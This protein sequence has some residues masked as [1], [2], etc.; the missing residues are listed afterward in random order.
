MNI[1]YCLPN[2][3]INTLEQIVKN[4]G[5]PSTRQRAGLVLLASVVR[6]SSRPASQYSPVGLSV[7]LDRYRKFG[8]YCLLPAWEHLQM[9]FTP[10]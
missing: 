5:D 10:V 4:H 7:L 1:L 6:K 8:F 9:K 2:D 3:E